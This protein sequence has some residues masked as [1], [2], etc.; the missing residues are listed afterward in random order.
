MAYMGFYQFEQPVDDFSAP[1]FKIELQ[2][3]MKRVYLWMALGLGISALVAFLTVNTALLEFALNRTVLMVAIFA[4]LGLVFA[5]SLGLNRMPMGLAL[6]LFFVYAALNGFTLSLILLAFEVGVVVSAFIT[7]AGL[8]GAISVIAL[9]TKLDLSKFGTF[10]IMGVIGLIIAGIVNMFM[11][12]RAFDFIIS[13]AGVLIFTGLT[14]YDTQ[15]IYRLAEEVPDASVD[16]LALMGALKL[17]L[18]F[19]NMFLYLLRLFGRRD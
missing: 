18:D 1:K 4:E 19:V 3:V 13:V 12:S 8:F 16:K 10:L 15:R 14:A 17:Y 5:L 2:A 11:Q 7:C 6:L 9:T